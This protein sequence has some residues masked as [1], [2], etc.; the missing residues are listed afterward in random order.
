[1][2]VLWLAIACSASIALIFRRSETAGMNRY[3]VT[4]ANYLTACLISILLLALRPPPLGLPPAPPADL[5]EI[6]SALGASDARLSPSGS[7]AWALLVGLGAGVV[8][9]LAFV[10]YQISVREHGVSLAGA[11]AKLG[12]L[13][14]MSL[15]LLLWQEYPRAIQWLGIALAIASILLVHWPPGRNWRA[16]IRV[17]LLLLFLFGGTAEFSNKIFQ[18]YA[19]QDYKLV[20]LLVTFFIAFLCSS[21]VA[22]ARRRPVRVAELLTGVAVGIP[23]LFSSFFLIAA[24]E[25]IPAAVAFPAYGAGT[26]VIIHLVGVTAFRERPTRRERLAILLT[27]VALILINL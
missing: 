14:P 27:V 20:F 4:S 12:I 7:F 21:S 25:T 15:S 9:F 26:I 8:F 23:N 24:L 10:Y 2:W 13:V 19:L 11:F 22:V 6:S 17:A 3:A 1:M 5:V 18:K 16:A